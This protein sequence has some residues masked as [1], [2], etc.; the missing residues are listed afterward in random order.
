MID[1]DEQI[2]EI[3]EISRI[4]PEVLEHYREA[5]DVALSNADGGSDTEDLRRGMVH[6]RTLFAV[7]IAPDARGE[8]G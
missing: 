2:G 6:Y 8:T 1:L 3:D 7:L 4:Y 5:H